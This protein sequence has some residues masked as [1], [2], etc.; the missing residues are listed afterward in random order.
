MSL[1]GGV[2]NEFVEGSPQIAAVDAAGVQAFGEKWTNGVNGGPPL[3]TLLSLAPD[4]LRQIK[5]GLAT[6]REQQQRRRKER[7]KKK[8]KKKK[9]K[10]QLGTGDG[11]GVAESHLAE[12]D[13]LSE[14]VE[15][16]YAGHSNLLARTSLL[17]QK[18][19][20]AAAG[21]RR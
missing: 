19:R 7:Q 3:R 2:A 15:E 6:S 21:Q 14:D 18:L 1:M 20:Q 8:K 13:G 16:G 10:K 11:A 5:E 17:A 4:D 9:K 12:F